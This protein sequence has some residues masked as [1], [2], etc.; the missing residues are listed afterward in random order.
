MKRKEKSKLKGAVQV[1]KRN[2]EEDKL[3]REECTKV[4][5][6]FKE[7]M[8]NELSEF[9]SEEGIDFSRIAKAFCNLVEKIHLANKVLKAK[10]C[11]D[12]YLPHI[13]I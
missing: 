10:I 13:T 4:I 11:G 12:G 7:W 2:A 8:T 9:E 1:L 6:A 3:S 5:V